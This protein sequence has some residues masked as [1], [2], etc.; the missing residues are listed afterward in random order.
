MA[1][2]AQVQRAYVDGQARTLEAVLDLIEE[3]E[4]EAWKENDANARLALVALRERVE[5]LDADE[6]YEIS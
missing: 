2:K 5:E 6:S 4:H 3:A 1:T